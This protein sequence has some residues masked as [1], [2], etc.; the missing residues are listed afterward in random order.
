[1]TDPHDTERRYLGRCVELAAEA[2]E[3][4]DEPFTPSIGP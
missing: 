1:V 3:A 4:G 2:L